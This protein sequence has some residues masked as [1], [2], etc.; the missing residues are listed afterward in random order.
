MVQN[1]PFDYEQ[2]PRVH[3]PTLV[4]E[5]Q[6]EGLTLQSNAVIPDITGDIVIDSRKI[7]KG[8][9]YIA[10]TG[11]T[12]D[13]HRFIRDAVGAGAAIILCEK[14]DPQITAPQILVR[15]S[16][17]AWAWSCSL[18][19]GH[20]G[21]GLKLIGV[22]GT[23][24]KTSTVWMIRAILNAYGIKTATIGTLGFYCG[25]EHFETTHTTPDP[26]VLYGLLARAKQ[27]GVTTLAMEVSSHAIAQKKLGP[28]KFHAAGMTSFSQDH[29]DLHGTMEEYL[30]TK[31][32]LFRQM[33]TPGAKIFLH[34]SVAEL[35]RSA[36]PADAAFTIYGHNAP[37]HLK[38]TSRTRHTRDATEVTMT[39][40]HA[41]H[42]V[43]H[44]PFIGEIFAN[45]FAGAMIAVSA[46]IK[47]VFASEDSSRIS[48][49]ILPVP[50]RLEPVKNEKP[51]RPLVLVDYSHTPD[52]LE[53]ALE[54]ARRVTS[55]KLF[56]IFGCGGDR[57]RTKR[58]LMAAIAA[59]LADLTCIT[60]DNPRTENPDAI[61]QEAAAGLPSDARESALLITDRK[62]AIQ[63]V[64]KRAG[65]C[66]TV[67]IAGKGH[68][69][70]QIIGHE[71]RH[72][73]DVEEAA[74]FL[75]TPR[76]WGV[77]GAGVSGLAAAFFLRKH[78]ES[79][80]VSDGGKVSAE[81]EEAL[82]RAGVKLFQGGHDLSH[83][84]GVE[85]LA[86][87]PG[88]PKTNLL[89]IDA[90]NKHLPLAT[91]IDL[92]LEHFKGAL[93][94][95]TGTNG[96][97]TTC[98]LIEHSLKALG[99]HAKACG[100][101]GVPPTALS[102]DDNRGDAFWVCELSSYQLERSHKLP[103][104]VA[105]VTSFSF[106]HLARHG[107]LRDYFLC[108]WQVASGLTKDDLLILR[109]EAYHQALSVGVSL[110][111]SRI[112]VIYD[113]KPET[114]LLSDPRVV[115]WWIDAGH[116]HS[117][118]GV[119]SELSGFELT[120]VHNAV[121][122]AFCTATI[123]HV[124]RCSVSEI[125][126]SFRAFQGLPYRCQP[127]G[128]TR[129]GDPITNDSKSTNLESTIIALLS[130]PKP[131]ILLMGGAGKGESYHDLN[132]H[133]RH[134]RGILTF[135][136]SRDVI[137]RDCPPDLLLGTYLHMADAVREA[138]AQADRLGC[139]ILFSPGCASFDEFRNYEH[140]G[141]EFNRLVVSK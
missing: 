106:D 135:G 100:N 104:K 42:S 131:V 121:N 101:I 66:D 26:P 54:E 92:G 122:A 141:E 35:C 45:N 48:R 139:G 102:N 61:I 118:E 108:K 64:L 23:N 3:L 39:D 105:I 53:K 88:V 93:I 57:D 99:R 116:I 113:G 111:P 8:S 44:I 112:L 78:G 49:S 76:S 32:T 11:G 38:L 41:I 68:E 77:V 47:D 84:A 74:R 40:A 46:V 128:K 81:S 119:V 6:N 126:Q 123:L 82:R 14:K 10:I 80:V 130:V 107:S 2:T 85:C 134:L 22:T 30:E 70:Y 16:R 137:A 97:S 67:L 50:G 140:R 4:Q 17:E 132:K 79:V 127:V 18:A 120:G 86:L 87:S 83:M 75:Q 133:T 31:L 58:P 110:P 138:L 24:G 27:Q 103:T 59:R 60:S 95:V 94:S 125:N 72:F 15:N 29:L 19:Y 56:C 71:K 136:A 21:L 90:E 36:I 109:A 55:G 62:A 20:P 65:G 34:E 13:G 114:K 89:L 9:V 129:L 52:A 124:L 63:T 117:L 73:S 25:E 115:S 5:L 33:L 28:L 7:T 91:E 96:K 51:W 12:H 69:T 98:A 1:V 43:Y 37:E